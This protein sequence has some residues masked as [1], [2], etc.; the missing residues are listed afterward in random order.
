MAITSRKRHTL[1]YYWTVRYVNSQGLYEEYGNTATM[2][3]LIVWITKHLE[4]LPKGEGK[5]ITKRAGT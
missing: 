1:S 2:T 5:L 4:E 3:E